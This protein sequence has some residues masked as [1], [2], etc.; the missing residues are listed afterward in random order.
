MKVF[1]GNFV[2]ADINGHVI[3]LTDEDGS[4]RVLDSITLDRGQW[5]NLIVWMGVNKP[6]SCTLQ[7]G[8]HD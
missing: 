2:Y 8:R 4:G 6:H 1:L 3:K 7:R 5:L